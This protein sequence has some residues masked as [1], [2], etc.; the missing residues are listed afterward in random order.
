MGQMSRMYGIYLGMK[1]YFSIDPV[2]FCVL[3]QYS[4]FCLRA[5]AKYG[6]GEDGTHWMT[7]S[8]NTMFPYLQA[9][10]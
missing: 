5:S 10:L 6:A 2:E 7:T 1:K 4:L 3:L 9:H 8:Y